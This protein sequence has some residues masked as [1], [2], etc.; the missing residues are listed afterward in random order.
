M[1]NWLPWKLCIFHSARVS[2]PLRTK[3]LH[4]SSDLMNDLSPMKN[5]PGCVARK[6]KLAPG[7]YVQIMNQLC[8]WV[9]FNSFLTLLTKNVCK[10]Q[11]STYNDI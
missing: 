1:L 7:I 2:K 6:V 9:I 11:L 8:S 10:N 5:C 3:R 4:I